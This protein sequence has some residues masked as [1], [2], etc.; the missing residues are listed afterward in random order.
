MLGRRVMVL[1]CA[2]GVHA[3]SVH[4][5]IA[6]GSKTIGAVWF[7]GDSI[8][9]GNADSDST[10]GMRANV[11]GKLAGASYTFTYTGHSTASAEGLPLTGSGPTGNL[12][13]Y[14]S[15]VSG[16]VIGTNTAT[17]TGITQNIP[18]W[19]ASSSSRL[20]VVKPSAILILIGSNDANSNIDI[21]H[22]P[23]RLATLLD[24]IYA[25]PGVGNPTILV[26]LIPPNHVSSTGT[27][28]VAFYNAAVPGV[29]R[30][31]QT[32]GKDI[33]LVDQFTLLNDNFATAMRSDG[34]HPNATGNEY[35]SQNW[36]KAIASCASQAPPPVPY[37]LTGTVTSA[38]VK[39]SWE[40][41]PGAYNG[42][43]VKRSL[44][45][46]GPYTTIATQWM[47]ASYTDA[48]NDGASTYYY[49]VSAVNAAGEGASSAPV[50]VPEW[51]GTPTLYIGDDAAEGAAV[52]A[53]S[54]TGDSVSTLTYAFVKGGTTYTNTTGNA[55]TVRLTEV[56]FYP[57]SNSGTLV[58]FVF[59]YAGGQTSG[60]VA[61]AAHYTVLRKGD[62][63]VVTANAAVQNVP[64]LSNGVAP[65]ITLNP[66]AVLGAGI[67]TSNNR[68]VRLQSTA[69]GLI[70][71]IYNGNSLPASLP[72]PFTANSSYSLDRILK[73]NVG[74]QPVSATPTP[75]PS[76]T[77]RPTPTSTP[78]PTAT[79]PTGG[80]V[81]IT[82]GAAGVSASTSDGNLPAN[83]IDNNLAT[84]WSASGDG[85]WIRFDL[86][87]VR[88][89][90]HVGLAV[91][92]GNARQNRFDLQTSA[93]GA[94]WTSVLTGASTSGTTT[95]EEIHDFADVDARFVRYVGHGSTVGT[96]NSLT[97]VS[98]FAPSGQVTPTSTP[99]PTPTPTPTPVGTPVEVTPP[100]SAVTASTQD[101][102]VPA[103][104]V[105]D[106]LAT[107][108]SA[109][110]DGQWVQFDLGAARTITHVKV[111][112][113][114]GNARRNAFD[115]QV[116]TG[117]GV[118]TTVWSGQSSGN[119]TAEETYEIADVPAR[120]VR[121]L[122]HGSSTTT[123]N[124][125]TEVSIF[126]TP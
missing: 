71:Y 62:P 43:N 8:T 75:T 28:N 111:A 124:S 14:H 67:A 35:M 24:T 84:R 22:A 44:T 105:D 117:G 32:A 86:G 46:G 55:Q 5:A 80:F 95:L 26:G 49:V 13:Q 83:T 15:G 37:G 31:F 107:R 40:I 45:S 42:Y 38:Q 33:Y 61:S 109:N 97:E 47:S 50:A 114:N 113:Y 98:L 123:F 65:T 89:V 51:A 92:N 68:L 118:W 21:T 93:D 120:W 3:P 82:P 73:F 59:T 6:P 110:G 100:A 91:Y 52:T 79:V 102:N 116:S 12:Y 88:T 41:V 81:E 74:I 121:Y 1:A 18:T 16:A 57:G 108:W 126:A 103:N 112:V 94:A 36:F 90:A 56:N 106:N 101:A 72:G 39:L 29:V 30:A 25:Q 11:Y 70:D 9:Q 69:Q 119:T 60:D 2:L 87:A 53:G 115:L 77:P 78:T 19:W 54:S 64:F 63:I 85:Q 76:P 58:P 4:A 10:G 48:S 17:Q 99:Q 27:A 7:V 20:S 34:L 104:T 66:G 23:E 125:V 122:G 96:F